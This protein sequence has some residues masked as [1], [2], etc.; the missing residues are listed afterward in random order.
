MYRIIL[1]LQLNWLQ[2]FYLLILTTPI[3][4]QPT[5][6]SPLQP[7]FGFFRPSIT[8]PLAN[9]PNFSYL[10]HLQCAL[11]FLH[12]LL[13]LLL[14]MSSDLSSPLTSMVLCLKILK[15][16]IFFL[17]QEL[18]WDFNKSKNHFPESTV[19]FKILHA[20]LGHP[21]T[22]CHFWSPSTPRRAWASDKSF[23][24]QQK[25]YFSMNLSFCNS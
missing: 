9:E 21:K 18:F 23:N 12:L 17:L 4:L 10:Q 15:Y 24:A 14:S 1:V 19:T 6:P 5:N 13:S 8:W 11:L 3:S 7:H 20:I 16:F 25:P 2:V 22:W